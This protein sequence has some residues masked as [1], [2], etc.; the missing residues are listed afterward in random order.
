MSSRI[1][2]LRYTSRRRFA[3]GAEPQGELGTHFRVWA[4]KSRNVSIVERFPQSN[5]QG[6]SRMLIPEGDGYHAGFV[7]ELSSGALYSL[8]LDNGL[9]P[10]PASRFQPEGPHGPSQVIDAGRFEWRD[11]GFRERR[12]ARV[13]YELHVGTFTPQG[14]YRAAAEQLAELADLGITV[15]EL[16]ALAAF[17]GRYGWSYDGVDLWA[18]SEAYGTPDDLRELVATAHGHGLAVI[19]DVVYN[20][21]GCD[22]NYL[23]AFS[24]DYFSQKH[25]SEWGDTLNFDGP[26]CSAVRAFVCENARYWIEEFHL[27]GLRV[28]ATQS[29]FDDTSPHILAQVTDA[30]RAGGA[31]LGKPLLIAAEN[32]PQDPKL[33]LPTAA[34]GYGFDAVWNDDFHHTARVALTGRHEGYYTD[35]RGSPQE[36][37]SALK[38][39]YLYQGQ[40]YQWQRK[41]RGRSA[42]HLEAHQFVVYLQNHDQIANQIPGDRIDRLTSSAELR[43]MTAL[44]LLSPPT[45]MLFQGQEF[46]ASSPFLFF[47]DQAP[48]LLPGIAQQRSKFL[49]QFPAMAGDRARQAQPAVSDQATFERCKLDF[50]ERELHRPIYQLHRDLLRLRR[51]DLVIRQRRADCMQGAALGDRALCLRFSS[52]QGERLLIANFGPDLEL[53]PAPEPLLAPPNGASWTSI[54]C[55]EDYAYGG[56]GAPPERDDGVIVVPARSSTL[57]CPRDEQTEAGGEVEDD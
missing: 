25:Q 22:G 29:I 17:G 10:D 1:S 45:P 30:A 43:A 7:T 15:I 46:A 28:D 44:M 20:H 55:S 4:P 2:D 42:L 52:A 33:L 32:E 48:S 40:H 49:A 21:V 6:Q 35:Y 11:A 27:D 9:Y 13:L 47:T 39:G 56:H 8:K 3:V 51:Q 38:R 54:W 53:A 19:L 12:D 41:A 37:I 34:G 14:T 36:L 5:V 23:P 31:A 16:M 24:D 18:P 57:F 50:D 26:N